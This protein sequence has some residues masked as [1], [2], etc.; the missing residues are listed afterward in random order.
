MLALGVLVLGACAPAPH[1]LSRRPE[2][3]AR[4]ELIRVEAFERQRARLEALLVIDN[5]GATLTVQEAD[6][7]VLL[8]ARSFATGTVRLR[9]EVAADEKATLS[10][11][12]A[13]AFLNLP[14]PVRERAEREEPVPLVVRGAL[15]AVRAGERLAIEFDGETELRLESDLD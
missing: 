6:F 13:L 15:H 11:P 1:V 8:D 7:E 4:V 5:P 9:A 3:S 2:P 10:L 12:V 14:R